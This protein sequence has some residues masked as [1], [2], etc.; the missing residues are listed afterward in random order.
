M[1]EAERWL[2]WAGEDIVLAEFA[3][4]RGIFRQT[5]F[6][7]QQAV[8]KVLKALLT[9]RR[10]GYPRGHSLEALLLHDPSVQEELRHWRAACRSLDVFYTATRYPDALPGLLPGGDPMEAEAVRALEDARAIVNDI[11]G[12][13]GPRM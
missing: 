10:G 4:S 1:G 3:L 13:I 6:H 2:E 11:R 8:E 5:C 7:A 9:V 12:R